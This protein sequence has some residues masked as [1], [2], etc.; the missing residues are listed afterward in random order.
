MDELTRGLPMLAAMSLYFATTWVLMI[1]LQ[2]ENI[3]ACQKI[4]DELTK[5]QKE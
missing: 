1:V 4:V 3:K 2:T 5:K